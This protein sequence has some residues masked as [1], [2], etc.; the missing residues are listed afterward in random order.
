M[1]DMQSLDEDRVERI[2]EAF[3]QLISI[4]AFEN[5]DQKYCTMG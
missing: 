3:S 4:N 5:P 1:C 2:L